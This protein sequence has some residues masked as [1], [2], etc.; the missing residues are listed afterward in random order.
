MKSL[1]CKLF[2]LAVLGVLAAAPAVAEHAGV[3]RLE[4]PVQ[5]GNVM[6]P[7]G[8]Y[9]FRASDLGVVSVFDQ[10]TTKYVAVTLANR[11]SPNVMKL[12]A[13]ATLS[14]DWAVRE[15]TLGGRCYRIFP[16][17][18]AETVASRPNVTTTVIALAR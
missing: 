5:V 11:Q 12:D 3:F 6:L 14:H 8:V 1:F 13:P 16:G 10:E 9:T 18:A 7:S 15:L 17:K 4:Q 2:S